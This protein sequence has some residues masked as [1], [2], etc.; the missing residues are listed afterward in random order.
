MNV[1][2]SL[3]VSNSPNMIA[4]TREDL[5]ALYDV[6]WN[7]NLSDHLEIKI[8]CDRQQKPI[9]LPQ[10][11]YLQHMLEQFA[12]DD[13]N[14]VTTPINVNTRLASLPTDGIMSNADLQY[15]EI[16]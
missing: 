1:D 16:V 4:N 10:D 8:Q 2:D 3:V 12:T 11:C 5:T 9:N 6:K 13:S 14:P 15:C 7:P